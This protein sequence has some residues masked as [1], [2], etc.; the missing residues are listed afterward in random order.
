MTRNAVAFRFSKDEGRLAENL[1]FTELFQK[2][3]EPYYWKDKNEVDFVMKNKD[4]SFDA[5]NLSYTN[6]IEDREISGLKELRDNFCEDI[7]EM[8]LLTKDVEKVEDNIKFIP[9]WKMDA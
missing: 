4:G 6:D 9:L 8:V 5:I 2:N 1:V 7:H 3:K